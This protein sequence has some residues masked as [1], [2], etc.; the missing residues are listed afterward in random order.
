[1][2]EKSRLAGRD[3]GVTGRIVAAIRIRYITRE[4]NDL[5]FTAVQ[6]VTVGARAMLLVTIYGDGIKSKRLRRPVFGGPLRV[7]LLRTGC[8]IAN[9]QPLYALQLQRVSAVTVLGCSTN[10]SSTTLLREITSQFRLTVQY[11]ILDLER[12]AIVHYI[13]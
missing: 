7:R 12:K 1:M 4:F 11:L 2:D 10:P 3:T 6:L 13:E 5:V 9:K 8:R